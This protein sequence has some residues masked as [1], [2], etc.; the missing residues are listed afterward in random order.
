[1]NEYVWTHYR[2]KLWG[3]PE[4]L[5]LKEYNDWAKQKI[6]THKPIIGIALTGT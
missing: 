5:E 1:M 6:K 4:A 3:L 2:Q